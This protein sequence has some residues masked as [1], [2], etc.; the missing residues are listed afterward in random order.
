[1]SRNSSKRWPMPC[2]AG[3]PARILS[4]RTR[5]HSARA[6]LPNRKNASRGSVAI[7]FG[8]PRPA[9]SICIAPALVVSLQSWIRW[10]F[11][12]KGESARSDFCVARLV[13]RASAIAGSPDLE[14]EGDATVDDVVELRVVLDDVFGPAE[15]E[16]PLLAHALDDQR[17]ERHEPLLRHL[18][19]V[20]G[21][22]VPEGERPAL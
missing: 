10:S 4:S 7:Q 14:I 18:V 6:N 1:M 8:L 21:V 19:V 3:M 16:L 11:S 9:F 13:L 20:D 17:V 5:R 15:G 2:L 12:S 22:L